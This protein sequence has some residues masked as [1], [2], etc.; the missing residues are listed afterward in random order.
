MRIWNE[1]EGN[2]TGTSGGSVESAQDAESRDQAEPFHCKGGM[3]E[4]TH[5][6]L[7][8]GPVIRF[9]RVT[10]EDRKSGMLPAEQ[11]IHDSR[12]DDLAGQQSL[13]EVVTE[14]MHHLF[15]INPGDRVELPVAGE[16]AVRSEAVK[17]GVEGDRIAAIGLN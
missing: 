17:M 13:K 16:G 4:I 12:G 10:P 5:K 2:R 7:C 14:E 15:C 11:K 3:Q 6:P 8:C 1:R 9:D